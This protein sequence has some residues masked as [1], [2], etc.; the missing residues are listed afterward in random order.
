M[1]L[2]D[3]LDRRRETAARHRENSGRLAQAY[4]EFTSTGQGTLEY[5]ER[6]DFN[7]IF[8]ERP[9]VSHAGVVDTQ[10][11]KDLVGRVALPQISGF[12]TEW[13]VDEADFYRGCWVAARIDFPTWEFIDLAV[14][15][16][17]DHHFTFTGI[18]LKNIEPE[19]DF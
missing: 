8:V 15:V 10:S 13:D 19:L 18:A 1:A 3:D 5:E 12:V 14:D 4:A 6:I 9:F 16:V 17:V 2:L 11:V 7:V